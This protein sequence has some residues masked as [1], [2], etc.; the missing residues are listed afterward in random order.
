MICQAK[1]TGV[2]RYNAQA[3]VDTAHRLIVTHEVTHVGS[4]RAQLAK[5]GTAAKAAMGRDA[6]QAVAD[7]GYFSG[8]EIEACAEAGIAPLAPADDRLWP[9]RGSVLQ[10]GP[11]LLCLA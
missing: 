5:M 1:G 4:D 2:V 6:L 11:C 10:R 3:G 9:G 7:R 8:P